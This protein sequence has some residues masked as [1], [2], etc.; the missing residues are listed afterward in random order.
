METPPRVNLSRN[1]NIFAK[2]N[3]REK[4]DKNHLL[5][6]RLKMSSPAAPLAT[7][8]GTSIIAPL[9]ATPFPSW[10]DM[11]DENPD[12]EIYETYESFEEEEAEFED[13]GEQKVR[14]WARPDGISR[15][16]SAK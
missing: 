1:P 4:T 15:K 2:V 3:F 11:V 14:R 5:L 16:W 6:T 9:F 13:S 7:S 8:L 10:G 12:D